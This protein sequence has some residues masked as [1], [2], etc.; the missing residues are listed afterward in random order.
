MIELSR[1]IAKWA[2]F[3][4]ESAIVIENLDPVVVLKCKF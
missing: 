2:K 4:D 3:A 1:T